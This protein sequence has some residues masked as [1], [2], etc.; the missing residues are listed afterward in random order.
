MITCAMEKK[1]GMMKRG[2][3]V[4]REKEMLTVNALVRV[5]LLRR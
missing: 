2:P 4:Q 1:R 3:Q 5:A